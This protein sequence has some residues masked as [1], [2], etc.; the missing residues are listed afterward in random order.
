MPSV[1]DAPTRPKANG[2]SYP[3]DSIAGTRIVAIA[4]TVATEEP[5]TAAKTAVAPT[6]VRARP[7]FSAP[8][9]TGRGRDVDI[10]LYDT[11]LY[12]MSYLGT[13]A[14]NSDYAP[15]RMERSAHA[16]LVPCQLYRASDGWLY[17][18][19]NKEKF[20]PLLCKGLGLP[21]LAHD[22]RFAS[23][24]LRRERRDELTEILD[25]ALRKHPADYWIKRL[26]GKVP[27]APVRTPR[28]ALID[29]D[30]SDSGRIQTLSLGSGAEFRMQRSP[31]QAGGSKKSAPCPPS[32]A[33]TR[34]Y[35]S[36]AGFSKEEIDDLERRGCI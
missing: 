16:S 35:L 6:Q 4:S 1:P 25:G 30:L 14:L 2:R 9:S 22:R 13:W 12:N 36:D 29:R 17:I 10:N 5:E 15:S 7:T 28:E 33:D 23:F 20:W 21:E 3:R 18:M 19:C 31:I 11:A 34:R 8:K 32:G 27:V 26:G 24:D